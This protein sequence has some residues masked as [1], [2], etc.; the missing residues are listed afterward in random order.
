[1]EPIVARY[2]QSALTPIAGALILI[3]WPQL[4]EASHAA[5][6]TERTIIH[7][8]A[9]AGR[10][11]ETGFRGPWVRNLHSVWLMPGIAYE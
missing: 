7:S 2:C 1:M 4:K 5:I 8:Y 9:K 11:I 3:K 10:V 6:V